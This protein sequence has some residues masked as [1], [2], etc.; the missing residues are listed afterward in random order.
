VASGKLVMNKSTVADVSDKRLMEKEK[1]EAGGAP[2]WYTCKHGKVCGLKSKC[3][4]CKM[5]KEEKK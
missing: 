2:G 4:K 3:D 5:E 1:L